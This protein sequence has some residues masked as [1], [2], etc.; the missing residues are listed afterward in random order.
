MYV[1]LAGAWST[2]CAWLRGGRTP[3]CARGPRSAGAR[4]PSTRTR[5][6]RT[7]RGGRPRTRTGR[8]NSWA[9]PGRACRRRAPT[10]GPRARGRTTTAT[11]TTSA[12]CRRGWSD[13]RGTSR[14]T[15]W[16]TGPLIFG[17]FW[18]RAKK[19]Y[20][21]N[22]GGGGGD[23]DILH[24]DAN[25]GNGRGNRTDPAAAAATET[26][27]RPR[28]HRRATTFLLGGTS[29]RAQGRARVYRNR[30]YIVCFYFIF[31][32]PPPYVGTRRRG[33][34]PART[35]AVLSRPL[36][37]SRWQLLVFRVRMFVSCFEWKLS[38]KKK[39]EIRKIIDF[40]KL[41][42]VVAS[43]L[44]RHREY[45]IEWPIVFFFRIRK[46]R[47][48]ITSEVFSLS[49]SLEIFKLRTKQFQRNKKKIL[50][51]H[52]ITHW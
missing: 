49:V 22:G 38:E 4:P 16:R 23:G 10:T 36:K 52:K 7:R 26:R 45:S 2:P 30:M 48:Y 41:K 18:R 35:N 40:G 15:T 43:S 21:G 19:R 37:V 12:T 5:T 24:G 1:L 39:V 42:F 47:C 20:R 31:F 46:P 51:K 14:A 13:R 32:I 44:D 9:R 6:N 25:D 3:S 50:T 34:R 11:T 17:P 8:R 29:V 27:P 28:P 33:Q